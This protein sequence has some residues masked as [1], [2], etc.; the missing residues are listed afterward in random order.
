MTTRV[1]PHN[2][3]IVWTDG[4]RLFAEVGGYVTTF[5]LTEGGLSQCLNLLRTRRVD[6]SG[7]PRLSRIEPTSGPG[8][9]LQQASAQAILR[10]MRVI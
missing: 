5:S 3:L 8:T 7:S 1:A 2:A 10:K 4:L 9:P 6:Y